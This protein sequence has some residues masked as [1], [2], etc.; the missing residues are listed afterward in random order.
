MPRKRRFHDSRR[1]ATTAQPQNIDTK[2]GDPPTETQVNANDV[3]A[4][5]AGRASP[6]RA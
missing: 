4:T 6:E 3:G 2:P 5:N 1:P